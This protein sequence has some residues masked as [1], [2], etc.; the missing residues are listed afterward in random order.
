MMR[1]ISTSMLKPGMTSPRGIPGSAFVSPPFEGGG[2]AVGG[3][4]HVSYDTYTPRR[5]TLTPFPGALSQRERGFTLIELLVTMGIVAIIATITIVGLR[6]VTEGSKI[7]SA[8]NTI[9]ATLDN[10]RGLAMEENTI[11]MVAFRAKLIGDDKQVVEA[12]TARFAGDTYVNNAGVLVDRFVP[13]PEVAA[14]ELPEGVKV[15][16]PFYESEIDFLWMATSDLPNVRG[17]NEVAGCIVS[18]MYGPDGETLRYNPRTDAVQSWVDFNPTF[19]FSEYGEVRQ[20]HA[21]DDYFPNAAQLVASIC[22]FGLDYTAFMCQQYQDDEPFVIPAPFLA[23]FN[24]EE[25]RT[26]YDTSTWT[27]AT[28]NGGLN[29]INNQSEYINQYAD[30]IHFNRYTGVVM[31]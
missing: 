1:E 21:G 6:A 12:V 28:A 22:D 11:V 16:A 19:D 5:R 20:R 31:K 24:D 7:A 15:A 25:C 3:A 27:G 18:V 13:I 2:D 29:R 30:R 4:L 17:N 14:R 8:R 10:A 26:F 23:V 9:T